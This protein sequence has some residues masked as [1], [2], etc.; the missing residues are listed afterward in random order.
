MRSLTTRMKKANCKRLDLCL[1]VCEL[2]PQLFMFGLF[3]L[4]SV[5][6][7]SCLVSVA[8]SSCF[9]VG[10]V[11][12]MLSFILQLMCMRDRL[13]GAISFCTRQIHYS[14]LEDLDVPK[15]WRLT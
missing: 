9:S 11:I 12:F 10:I 13:I 15:D 8:I 7:G 3:F 6:M 4:L 1:S 2:L 5:R 14:S